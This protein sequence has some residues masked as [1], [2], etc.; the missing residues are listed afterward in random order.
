MAPFDHD[1]RACI[2]AW[3]LHRLETAM[4]RLYGARKRHIYGTLPERL[5]EIGAGAGAN[6][7][8]YAPNTRLIA[9]EPNVAIHP[10]LRQKAARHA[11]QLEIQ[12]SGAE[13][14]ALAD[15]CV[16]AVVGTLVLCSVQDPQ[17]VVSEVRRILQPGGRYLFL[18]H[19]AAL[20]GSRL[21]GMQNT[22]LRP[23]RWLF[24]GCHLN[25]ETF[26]VISRAGFSHVAMDCFVQ[27]RL[28]PFA[29]HIFGVA[30]K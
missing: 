19:V 21:R 26:T 20:P 18:E 8:Y 27:P 11:I 2:N 15:A 24:E 29:P 4:H 12:G 17:A 6:L 25:R 10:R 3:L 28:L 1:H 7:R 14:I 9:I 23:W 16:D 22:L 30:V 13:R 5:V